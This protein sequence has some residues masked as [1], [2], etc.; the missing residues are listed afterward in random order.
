[1]SRVEVEGH[2]AERPGPRARPVEG[3][4]EDDVRLLQHRGDGPLEPEL[5]PHTVVVDP[6]HDGE[7]RRRREPERAPGRTDPRPPRLPCLRRRRPRRAQLFT[8]PS[9][10]PSWS[11]IS[12]W[13]RPFQ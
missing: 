7:E 9:G 13:V 2:L 12:A 5:L 10:A 6:E 3:E 1:L 8:V 4:R 11:A